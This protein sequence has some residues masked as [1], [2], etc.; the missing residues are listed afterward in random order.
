[1]ANGRITQVIDSTRYVWAKGASFIAAYP[2]AADY[3]KSVPTDM[4]QIP[5]WVNVAQVDEAAYGII[6]GLIAGGAI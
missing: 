1:V 6:C 3:P 5:G 2:V 4:H